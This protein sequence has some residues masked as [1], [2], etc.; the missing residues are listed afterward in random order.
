M[1]YIYVCGLYDT[2]SD[3]GFIV[4]T[5]NQILN[6]ADRGNFVAQKIMVT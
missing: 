1:L 4:L 2:L 6:T 5:W 3:V